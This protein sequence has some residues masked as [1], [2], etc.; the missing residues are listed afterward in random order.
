M[1]PFEMNTGENKLNETFL[2]LGNA[3]NHRKYGSKHSFSV[4]MERH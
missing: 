3:K 1:A 2:L 4:L